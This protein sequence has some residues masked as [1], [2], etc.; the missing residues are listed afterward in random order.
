VSIASDADA[1]HAPAYKMLPPLTETVMAGRETVMQFINP[2]EALNGPMCMLVT[3]QSDVFFSLFHI[4]MDFTY[5]YIY[6]CVSI[7]SIFQCWHHQ[8]LLFGFKAGCPF[9]RQAWIPRIARDDP[10]SK[11]QEKVPIVAVVPSG[12]S[13]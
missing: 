1:P 3:A 5:V 2:D 6:V 7:Y 12:Y 8:S 9:F 10:P 11:L 4:L 13:T